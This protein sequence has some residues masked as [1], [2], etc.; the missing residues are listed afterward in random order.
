ML[1][2]GADLSEGAAARPEVVRG[3]AA[4]LLSR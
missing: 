3:N 2:E 1:A 4:V